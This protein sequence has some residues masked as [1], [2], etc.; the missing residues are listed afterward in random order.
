[1][2][3]VGQAGQRIVHG[4]MGQAL[5]GPQ[6]LADL[7]EQLLVDL[8][9][10]TRAFLHALFQFGMRHTQPLLVA[11]ARQPGSDVLRNERQQP[12]IVHAE[13]TVLAVTLHHDRTDHLVIAQQR[14]AQPAMRARAGFTHLATGQQRIDL[15]A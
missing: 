7:A 3:P 15:G 4:L 6:A 9:Q 5:L 2:Q 14:H 12:L 8:G 13:R 1:M 10:L 11:L